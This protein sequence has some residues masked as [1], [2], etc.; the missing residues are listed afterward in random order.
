MRLHVDFHVLL[1][2]STWQGK[3][4]PYVIS[5]APRMAHTQNHSSGRL[6]IIIVR[7]PIFIIA[8]LGRNPHDYGP[9]V[10]YRR[11]V[12]AR[13]GRVIMNFDKATTLVIAESVKRGERHLSSDVC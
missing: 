9:G 2:C 5:P 12:A 11:S 4:E 7:V 3:I 1:A 8:S 6:M 10:Q 13:R